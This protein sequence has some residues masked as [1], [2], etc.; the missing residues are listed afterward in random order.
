[1]RSV[2]LDTVAGLLVFGLCFGAIGWR[3]YQSSTAGKAPS[4]KLVL[5]F[6]LSLLIIAAVAIAT[7]GVSI[8]AIY[9]LDRAGL[10]LGKAGV[11]LAIG[12]C[13]GATAWTWRGRTSSGSSQ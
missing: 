1:M 3:A 13:L 6:C 12:A 7:L 9:E 8:L 5:S 2:S 11:A 4:P 10:P